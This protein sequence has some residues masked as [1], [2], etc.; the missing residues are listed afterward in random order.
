MIRV[1]RTDTG[2][3]DAGAGSGGPKLTTPAGRG[4]MCKQLRRVSQHAGPCPMSAPQIP[5]KKAEIPPM[6]LQEE[7][8]RFFMN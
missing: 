3:V 1:L 8:I 2:M 6:P 5:R 7:L 4:S